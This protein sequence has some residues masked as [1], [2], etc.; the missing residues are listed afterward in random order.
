MS[1]VVTHLGAFGINDV[2]INIDPDITF[3]RTVIPRHSHFARDRQQLEFSGT[4]GYGRSA[5]CEV[6]RNG[7]LLANLWVVLEL[8]AFNSGA[9][10]VRCVDDIGRAIIEY[11]RLKSGGTTFAE[12]QGMWLH[13]EDELFKSGEQSYG[14]VTGKA[15]NVRELEVLA[16]RVQKLY[17]PLTFWFTK[18]PGM[19][20]PL[21]ATHLTKLN[22]E[23]KLKARTYLSKATTAASFTPA[24]GD[25]D[26]NDLYI[27]AEYVY[28]ID[29]ERTWFVNN[30]HRW[31]MEQIQAESPT[32]I[33][34]GST[35]ATIDLSVNHSI[36]GFY[37]AFVQSSHGEGGADPEPFNFVGQETGKYL[38]HAFNTFYLKINANN[39]N[40]QP[41]DPLFLNVVMNAEHFGKVPGKQIY[42]FLHS[43]K[44]KQYGS[45]GIMNMSRID[46][47]KLVFTFGAAL[48]NAMDLYVYHHAIN[49]VTLNGGVLQLEFAN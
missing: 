30:P 9:G 45:T 12:L 36:K 3:F 39:Y 31:T 35:T 5:N 1:G 38:Y 49:T 29:D 23:V 11:V 13:I 42:S 48:S 32:T 25:G 20:L 10:N 15:H 17:I 33:A 19:H 26:I 16:A 8:S 6:Q 40:T 22:C 7:D 27:L 4:T 2:D 21:V 18:D 24:S 46:Q 41:L 43:L 34:S 14:A 28:L 37:F 47:K 44:P